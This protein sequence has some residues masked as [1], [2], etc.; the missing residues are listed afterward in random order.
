M[1]TTYVKFVDVLWRNLKKQLFHIEI[2]KVKVEPWKQCFCNEMNEKKHCNQESR[3]R[4]CMLY[5]ECITWI[6]K[7][8]SPKVTWV[9]YYLTY[10]QINNKLRVI[11][12][13][14][15]KANKNCGTGVVSTQLCI[16]RQLL[17]RFSCTKCACSC[18]I[19]M[20][21]MANTV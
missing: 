9:V 12:V 6:T 1:A 20:L 19:K 3:G 15:K 21:E 7:I 17:I 2:N 18:N 4:E 5:F 11:L 10:L 8:N 13:L 14:V 16:R